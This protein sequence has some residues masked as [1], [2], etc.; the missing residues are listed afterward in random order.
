LLDSIKSAFKT[1]TEKEKYILLLR[2]DVIQDI[3]E[4]QEEIERILSEERAV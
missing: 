1:L 2:F 4:S 3:P